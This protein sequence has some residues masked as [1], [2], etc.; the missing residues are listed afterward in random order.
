MV[1]RIFIEKQ[2]VAL[3]KH[4][5]KKNVEEYID[6]DRTVIA[7]QEHFNFVGAAT[8]YQRERA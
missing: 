5:K 2:K 8:A 3:C 1:R 4:Q 7:S 6:R